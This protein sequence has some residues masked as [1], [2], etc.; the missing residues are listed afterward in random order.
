[1]GAGKGRGQQG[2]GSTARESLREPGGATAEATTITVRV[3][4]NFGVRTLGLGGRR[5][6]LVHVGG[7]WFGFPIELLRFL[8]PL[9]DEIAARS[10]DIGDRT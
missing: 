4:Q 8:F 2:Q 6:V 3:S 5:L 9:P 10:R 1:V 7:G